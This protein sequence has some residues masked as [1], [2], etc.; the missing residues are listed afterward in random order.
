MR[1]DLISSIGTNGI[2][3]VF[4]SD[5]SDSGDLIIEHSYDGRDLD[6]E[7]A[8]QVIDRVREIWPTDVKFFTIIEEDPWEI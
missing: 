5:I 6:L 4:V 7:Y 1:D 2:P 3:Q 8:E